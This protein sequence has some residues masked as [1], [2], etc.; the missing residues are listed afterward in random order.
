MASVR[1]SDIIDVK[2]FQDL[3]PVDGP[4][5]TAFYESGI[6]TRNPLLDQVASGPGLIAELPFWNDIDP[7]DA[8][9]LSNDDTSVNAS[10]SKITQGSQIGRKAHLNKGWSETDLAAELAM[11]GDAMARIR[12]RFDRYWTR[13]WQRRLVA[14]CSGLIA[15][16]I[17]SNSGDMVVDVGTFG[18]V[19]ATNRFTRSN[20]TAAAFTLGDAYSTVSA[21]AVHSVIY[22]QM[23]DNDDI[24]FIPDSEGQMTIP[25]YLG[26]RVIVD[27]GL[28][29]IADTSEPYDAPK[30][31][32]IIFGEGAF[33]WGEGTPRVPVEVDRKPSGGNGGG[34]EELW[35]RK[36]WLLHPF[37]YKV[38]ATASPN[39]VRPL[40]GVSF[41]LAE[42]EAAG[43][44]ERV[45]PRKLV[46]MAFLITN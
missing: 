2:V 36:T 28:P 40:N 7:A 39:P 43:I 25:T 14:T 21:V 4:E 9:N 41:S 15:H 29:V 30:Y 46:P 38:Q 13:Q 1:L 32:S 17:A 3:P 34:V 31:T 5:L 19:G 20:F 26:H 16:N 6:I 42:L 45:L 8:P 18:T 23:V 12:A 22:K 10:T 33:G 37:G 44:Y 24:D 35:T 11:G 27:D